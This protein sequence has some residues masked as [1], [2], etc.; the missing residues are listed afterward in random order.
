[1]SPGVG[2][3]VHTCGDG[4]L[5][6]NH[7]EQVELQLTRA[8]SPSPPCTSRRSPPIFDYEY[9]DFDRWTTSATAQIKA[10]VAV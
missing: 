9:E 3:F 8:P 4:H 5:Y 7:L 6:S 2:D 10:A 1:M